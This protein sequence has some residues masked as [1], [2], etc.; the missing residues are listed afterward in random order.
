MARS[1]CLPVLL[2]HL[3]F[4]HADCRRIDTFLEKNIATG[5]SLEKGETARCN[6]ATNCAVCKLVKA[7]RPGRFPKRDPQRHQWLEV[8]AYLSTDICGPISPTSET[9]HRYL[10]VFVCRS[11]GYT[12]TYFLKKKSDA[13]D[14]LNEFL[15]DIKQ[16]GHRP[17]NITIKSVYIH[18]WPLPASVPRTWHHLRLL[19]SSRA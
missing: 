8:N 13:S 18:P 6:P 19:N 5:I 12:H 9:G 11:T 15:D 1:Q 7:P 2:S 4:G 17:E 3:R 16:S 10:I 14:V